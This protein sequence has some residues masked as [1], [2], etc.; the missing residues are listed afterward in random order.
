[1][2]A[3]DT[4][5]RDEFLSPL[6]IQLR[7]RAMRMP[8]ANAFVS[9]SA[10]CSTPGATLSW[11][12]WY[13][14]SSAIAACLITA[15][16][17]IG[18]RVAVMAGNRSLWPIADI[19]IQMIG[20][21]GVGIYPTSSPSQVVALLH[22]ADV[23]VVLAA[24]DAH[25]TLLRSIRAEQGLSFELIVDVAAES[26]SGEQL[27]SEWLA[28]GHAL[29]REAGIQDAIAAR[30][31]ALTLDH[32]AG[33]IYTSG[34]TGVPKGACISHRYLAASARS[35]A[36]V[37]DLTDA[38][39][40]LSFLPY[41]HAAERVFGQC[42]RIAT[43]MSAALIEDAA[44]V[45]RIAR[46]FEPT[47]LGGLPRIFERLHEAVNVA[48][49]SGTDPREAITSRIGSQCR[50]A[51]SGGANMPTHIARDLE[52]LGLLVLGAYGQTEHLCVAM[53]RPSHVRF[54]SVGEPMPGTRVH[55]ADDGELLVERSALTFSGYWNDDEATRAAFTADGR[56]LK[57][58][59]RAEQDADGM[60]RI[61]GRV[62]ELIALSTGRK[63]APLPIESAL[64]ESPFI[65][66]AVCYGEGRKYLTALIALRRAAVER[67]ASDRGLVA[68]WPALAQ[69]PDVCTLIDD[70]V[71]RVNASLARTD[72]IQ[73]F[74]IID[75]EFT[76][77][78]GELTPTFKVVRAVITAR[79][80]AP[81]EALYT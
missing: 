81:L 26:T 66:N 39:R 10:G 2:I 73:R 13:Q 31:D 62:K 7:E 45:F 16:V 18:D 65:A 79:Y 61:T 50:L 59:D 38:D 3:N 35:I 11:S 4:L 78:G 43:G 30:L 80:A 69:H 12:A 63:I 9:F 67:W 25:A 24:G 74:A 17:Q 29:T 34:S 68:T 37:L 19:A 41:S 28:R 49:Q 53:N 36:H 5:L 23:R 44:D 75:H 14:S 70:A 52:H 77:E 57:T 72:G 32:I 71:A 51:T 27:W 60:L 8:E 64:S 58:G 1:M 47:L 46:V 6:P 15:G 76:L 54:D 56:W 20:A 40:S 21:I 48:R 22:D 33:L 42:T 55:I